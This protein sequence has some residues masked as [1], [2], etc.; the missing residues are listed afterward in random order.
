MGDDEADV[1]FLERPPRPG[2]AE[3]IDP[4]KRQKK[5]EPARGVEVL[6]GER[7]AV[8][9]LEDRRDRQDHGETGDQGDRQP[10]GTE[11]FENFHRFGIISEQKEW[12]DF[13]HHF[14]E[15]TQEKHVR[16]N[17]DLPEAHVY[18]LSAS[19]RCFEGKR[20]RFQGRKLLHRPFFEGPS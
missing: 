17:H 12:F 7:R 4:Q 13:A 16:E 1:L 9:G 14:F 8:D 11:Y 3:D 10:E 6:L 5:I 19:L 2:R 15:L 20:G 18:D